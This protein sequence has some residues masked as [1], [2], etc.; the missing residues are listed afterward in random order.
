M[1]TQNPD[2]LVLQWQ[3]LSSAS[4]SSTLKKM[5]ALSALMTMLMTSL[6]PIASWQKVQRY[7]M[8]LPP[9]IQVTVNLMIIKNPVTVNLLS[10]PLNN[11]TAL[12]KLQKLLEKSDDLL[13]EEMNLNKILADDM[14]IFSLDLI[15]FRIVMIHSSLIM[16]SFPMNFFK[17]SLILRSSGCLMM[18]FVWK[19]IHY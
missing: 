16:R 4:Q 15:F 18:I 2:R 5:I 1:K 6:Q 3:P 10:L 14:K 9:L 8:M 12:E 17:G 19:M 7:R 11:K 13:N